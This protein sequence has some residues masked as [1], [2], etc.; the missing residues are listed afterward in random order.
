MEGDVEQPRLLISSSRKPVSYI[1]LAKR[2]LQEHGEVQLSALGVAISS[3]VTLAEILKNKQLAVET[4]VVT[5]LEEISSE[6]RTRHKPKM[7]VTLKKS[8]QF[9]D[10]LAAEGAR[11]SFGQ[12]MG[13]GFGGEDSDPRPGHSSGGSIRHLRGG[14]AGSGSARSGGPGLAYSPDAMQQLLSERLA[15]PGMGNYASSGSMS[16]GGSRDYLGGGGGSLGSYEASPA[17]MAYHGG[18]GP[19][20]Q[21]FLGAGSHELQQSLGSMDARGGGGRQQMSPGP[22]SGGVHQQ[23]ASGGYLSGGQQYPGAGPPT[24]QQQQYAYLLQ[25]QLQLA[26]QQAHEA[27]QQ[28]QHQQLAQQLASLQL[29]QQQAAKD[30]Q[31]A[32]QSLSYLGSPH[33]Q[34]PPQQQHEQQLQQP[35]H[36]Q[37][38]QSVPSPYTPELQQ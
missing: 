4:R 7:S 14:N 27:Q 11:T 6:S 12:G 2:F 1:N 32:H 24:S 33:G 37:P 30:Q 25:Q 19:Q 34:L 9:D 31:A 8:P 20:L 18:S 3:M 15:H 10:I 35:S 36:Q 26:Q 5:S 17:G 23:Q 22:W 38:Q 28:Q 13:S 21:Q 16:G 29:A